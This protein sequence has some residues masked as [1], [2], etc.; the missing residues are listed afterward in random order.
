MIGFTVYALYDTQPNRK[1]SCPIGLVRFRNVSFFVTCWHSV[2]NLLV[3][4]GTTSGLALEKTV[5]SAILDIY[6][7]SQG[8]CPTHIRCP[9]SIC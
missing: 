5:S 4:H 9:S 3:T 8:L 7:L 2:R 6:V 1:Q